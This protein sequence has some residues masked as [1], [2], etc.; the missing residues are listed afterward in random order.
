MHSWVED[1]AHAARLDRWPAES[2]VQ[3]FFAPTETTPAKG[4][5]V[6]LALRRAPRAPRPAEHSR[7]LT[8]AKPDVGTLAQM[9]QLRGRRSSPMG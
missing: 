5:R 4:P 2:L 1:I 6:P 9:N 8:G 3:V 7:G